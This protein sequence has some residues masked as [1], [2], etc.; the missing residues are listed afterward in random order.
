[1]C[2]LRDKCRSG[3]MWVTQKASTSV[4]RCVSAVNCVNEDDLAI[5][6]NQRCGNSGAAYLAASFIQ[7]GG[8]LSMMIKGAYTI[9]THGKI[10]AIS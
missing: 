6:M 5:K 7:V 4:V 9:D 8:R 1:M 2:C 10:T 3:V